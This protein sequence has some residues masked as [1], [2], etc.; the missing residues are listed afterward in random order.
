[1]AGTF[2]HINLYTNNVS[3][4]KIRTTYGAIIGGKYKYKFLQSDAREFYINGI[5]DKLVLGSLEIKQ[6]FVV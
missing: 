5:Y 4:I 6:L 2:T 1:M 3:H